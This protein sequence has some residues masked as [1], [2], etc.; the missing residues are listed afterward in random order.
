MRSA[1]HDTDDDPGGGL[2]N[3]RCAPGPTHEPESVELRPE[4]PE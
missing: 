3:H 2:R 4:D 1:P